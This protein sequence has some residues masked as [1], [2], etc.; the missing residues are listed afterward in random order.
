MNGR[1]HIRQVMLIDET[2]TALGV[3][4][5]HEAMRLAHE[6]GLDLVE[7]SPNQRPPVAKLLDYGKFKYEQNRK[8]REG[9]KHQRAGDVKEIRFRPRTDTHDVETKV[10]RMAKFLRAGAKVKAT[11]RMRGRER[12]Y[13]E[14]A[15]QL[16][17]NVVERLDT[18]AVVE[19]PIVREGN[20]S[21]AVILIPG[22][23][24]GGGEAPG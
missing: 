14:L 21:F 8:E 23:G 24:A 13:P 10:N 12:I 7:V 6:R 17:N 18:L 5:T 19:R 9:R 20:N 3:V 22:P 15:A 1:I 2:N 16:L 11:V 4:D